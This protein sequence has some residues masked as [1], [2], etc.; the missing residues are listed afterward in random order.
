MIFYA[1]QALWEVM[2]NYHKVI[3]WHEQYDPA[4]HVTASDVSDENKDDEKTAEATYN[5]NYIRQKLDHGL[6]RI[7]KVTFI[8]FLLL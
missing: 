7:W 2:L 5:R 8:S 1:Y 4:M 3:C 6:N